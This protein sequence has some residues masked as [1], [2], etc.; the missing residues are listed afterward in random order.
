MSEEN[1]YI[2]QRESETL[3]HLVSQ[4]YG[5]DFSGYASASFNRR[6]SRILLLNQMDF[7]SLL[8]LLQKD[9]EFFNF[10]LEEITV[11]V[12]EMFRDPSFYAALR[13][14]VIPQMQTYPVI[15]IWHAGC[16]TGEEVY[17][18]A[19][20]LKEAGLLNR[21]L[22][23]AT[24][25]SQQALSTAMNGLYP[26]E[27]FDKSK[28]NYLASGGKHAFEDNFEWKNGQFCFPDSFKKRIVFSHHNLV[29]DESF[30][31]F[32]IIFCRNVMI[33]FNRYLQDKVLQLLTKSLA[34]LGYL[35]LGTKESIE[36]T[37]VAGLYEPVSAKEKLFRKKG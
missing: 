16:A 5:Y 35:A 4:I 30:N 6:V 23:Y 34:P 2:S 18:T 36:F 9:A 25:I 26:A 12:T 21:S 15:R 22:L 27:Q 20:L 29:T 13:Q 11:N 8:Q 37:S 32:N 19:I 28:E 7:S 31:E 1:E 24:D 33:Y 17:S 14:Q 10:F 3:I